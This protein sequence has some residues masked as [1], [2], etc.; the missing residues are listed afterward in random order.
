MK[1]GSTLGPWFLG[2]GDGKA[3]RIPTANS[4]ASAHVQKG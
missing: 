3:R 2:E 4:L 1:R